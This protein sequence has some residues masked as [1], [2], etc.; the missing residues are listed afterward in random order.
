MRKFLALLLLT[1]GGCKAGP[2]ET[3]STLELPLTAVT[4]APPPRLPHL[5]RLG[6]P[7]ADERGGRRRAGAR[8]A[9]HAPTGRGGEDPTADRPAAHRGVAGGGANR[10]G[11]EPGQPRGVLA[12]ARRGGG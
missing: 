6:H 5:R 7:G 8:R 9:S 12:P 1:V 10:P 3:P 4:D 2:P 11:A